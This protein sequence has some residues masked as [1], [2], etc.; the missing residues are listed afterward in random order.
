MEVR[1]AK[2]LVSAGVVALFSA[3]GHSLSRVANVPDGHGAL[4]A[5]AGAGAA[6]VALIIGW[7]VGPA[8]RA[9]A[10]RGAPRSFL[11]IKVFTIGFL[12]ATSGWLGGV[13]IHGGVDRVLDCGI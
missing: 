12:I 5:L 11:G 9:I 2:L 4:L 3:V 1:N 10:N 7:I 6:C 8:A 13:Y